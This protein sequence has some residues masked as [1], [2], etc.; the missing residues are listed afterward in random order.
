MVAPRE[1]ASSVAAPAREAPAPARY[2]HRPAVAAATPSATARAAMSVPDWLCHGSAIHRSIEEA[3][4]E[5]PYQP[6]SPIHHAL[7]PAIRPTATRATGPQSTFQ[8][9]IVASPITSIAP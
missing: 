1:P 3:S 4:R 8:M 6:S 9:A 5:L 2:L 7:A